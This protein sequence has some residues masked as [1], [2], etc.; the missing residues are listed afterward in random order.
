VISNNK[1]ERETPLTSN[2][3]PEL[4]LSWRG[5]DFSTAGSAEEDDEDEYLAAVVMLVSL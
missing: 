3:E 1:S 5:I 4:K 2:L